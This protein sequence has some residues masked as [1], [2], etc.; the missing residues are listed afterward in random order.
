MAN[1]IAKPAVQ[2]PSPRKVTLL[3]G[4]K[5]DS[6]FT[7]VEHTL[8]TRGIEFE[9]CEWGQ[10][11]PEDQDIISF[12][13]L[14]EKPLLE[15]IGQEDLTK[16]LNLVDSSSESN[17]IWLIP[18]TQIRPSNP[19]T[20][21]ILS[22]IRTIRSEIASAFATLELDNTEIGAAGAVADV[23]IKIQRSKD[24]EDDINIDMEWAW[25]NGALNVG[26]FH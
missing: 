11:L 22:L 7:E 23:L 26:R 2:Y 14:A 1:I 16:L 24:K 19:Y 12:L 17:I 18:A 25:S 13:D 20:G 6:L 5:K 4:S 3:H 21:Q 10:E 9:S 8:R 15:N